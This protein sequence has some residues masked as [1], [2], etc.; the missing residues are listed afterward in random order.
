MAVAL[1]ITTDSHE[2]LR[3]GTQQHLPTFV[4]KSVFEPSTGLM[5]RDSQH[6]PMTLTTRA[7]ELTKVGRY[8]LLMVAI[9]TTHSGRLQSAPCTRKYMKNAV[10]GTEPT[11]TRANGPIPAILQLQPPR[12]RCLYATGRLCRQQPS[13]STAT[14]SGDGCTDS[15]VLRRPTRRCRRAQSPC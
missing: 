2:R 7:H 6:R 13:C 5:D 4:S 11:N 1:M 15:F 9:H 3:A 8:A 10:F 14:S 12:I